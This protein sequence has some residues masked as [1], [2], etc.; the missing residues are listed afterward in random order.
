M[1]SLIKQLKSSFERVSPSNPSDCLCSG[2]FSFYMS[3]LS[4]SFILISSIRL[5][6][7]T[8][9]LHPQHLCFLYELRIT[10]WPLTSD[11]IM[12]H[13]AKI[14][15]WKRG[16]LGSHSVRVLTLYFNVNAFPGFSHKCV[17]HSGKVSG[18]DTSYFTVCLHSQ[19]I[20]LKA[21][22]DSCWLSNPLYMWC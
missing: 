22:N 17:K 15:N 16:R 5:C 10:W 2:P 13:S 14:Q 18:R 19:W 1:F 9:S 20:A 7:N 8:I 3:E 12:S 6:R 21:F 11:L 4:V